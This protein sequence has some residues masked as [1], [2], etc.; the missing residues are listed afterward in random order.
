MRRMELGRGVPGNS[1]LGFRDR[2]PSS[3]LAQAGSERDLARSLLT[4][5]RGGVCWSWGEL[6]DG[7]LGLIRFFSP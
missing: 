2:A 6:G 1:S 4:P 3:D 7:L 5:M